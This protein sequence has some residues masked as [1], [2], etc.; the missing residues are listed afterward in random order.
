[1]AD[2]KPQPVLSADILLVQL[3]VPD[4]ISSRYRNICKKHA[5]LQLLNR[6]VSH[7][8]TLILNEFLSLKIVSVKAVEDGTQGIKARNNDGLR[9]QKGG[10]AGNELRCDDVLLDRKFVVST[11]TRILF[12]SD[13]VDIVPD[14]VAIAHSDKRTGAHVSDS[15]NSSSNQ[16]GNANYT[17]I[18]NNNHDNN[19]NKSEKKRTRNENQCY[20]AKER[21]RILMEM[22]RN[23]ISEDKL[24][25]KI[26]NL[27]VQGLSH[28][29]VNCQKVIVCPLKGEKN[30]RNENEKGEI[31]RNE[32]NNQDGMEIGNA[33]ER[34][35][36]DNKKSDLQNDKDSFS[37]FN[38]TTG[39][40]IK[41]ET[42]G[43]KS[44]LLRTLHRTFGPSRSVLLSAKNLNGKNRYESGVKG[45]IMRTVKTV[46]TVKTAKKNVHGVLMENISRFFH[47]VRCSSM[48]V[49]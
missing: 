24:L 35:K 38:M 44:H 49:D 31:I 21:K 37:L 14:P 17:D 18:S 46:K 3:L 11:T 45:E 23:I 32:M 30:E 8:E 42:G 2:T 39:M 9:N 26:R 1:M 33:Y 10:N 6:V 13:D 19:H 36:H 29:S 47:T 28:L 34:N 16:N 7:G 22:K 4:K 41:A 40:I 12:L 43:G 25:I 20:Q 48:D 27:M 5:K 15:E